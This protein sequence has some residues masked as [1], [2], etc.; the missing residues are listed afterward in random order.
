MRKIIAVALLPLLAIS[1]AITPVSAAQIHGSQA[2][3]GIV[4]GGSGITRVQATF[5][6]P[7][8][9]TRCG[10]DS[11]V[12]TWVGLGGYGFYGSNRFSQLG[13]DAS[14]R[15]HSAWYELFDGNGN[16]P[17]VSVPFVYKTGDRI[18]LAERFNA[19]HTRLYF[20]W[21]N[22][23]THKAVYRTVYQAWRYYSGRG[24]EWV[25]AESPYGGGRYPLAYFGRIVYRNATYGGPNWTRSLSPAQ[26]LINMYGGIDPDHT[27]ATVNV[28]GAR[29]FNVQWRRCS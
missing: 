25:P 28:T 20:T 2:W 24:A 10:P 7:R 13:L 27:L 26:Y 22:L 16:G 23:T 29:Q 11:N 3:A 4:D 1:T 9:G 18:L 12:A 6:W 17:V 21:S 15:A 8:I 19:R 5:D 14:P